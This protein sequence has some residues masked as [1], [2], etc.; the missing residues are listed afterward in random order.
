LGGTGSF[1][2]QTYL[3]AAIVAPLTIISSFFGL[4][5]YIGLCLS[6]ILN[7]YEFVLS[8]FVIKV[9]HDFDSTKAVMTIIL[10]VV[11]FFLCTFI[12]SLGVM[13]RH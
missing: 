4:I 5:P 2:A 3:L 7:I 1:E 12:G 6:L 13:A 10:P 8:Y 9:A 11:V